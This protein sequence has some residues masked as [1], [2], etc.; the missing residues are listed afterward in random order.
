MDVE[1]VRR[2]LEDLPEVE[3]CGVRPPHPDGPDVLSAYVVPRRALRAGADGLAGRQVAEW[4]SLYD[5][6]YLRPDSE[7]A[8]FDV[9]GWVSSYTDLEVPATE[10]AEWLGRA[11]SRIGALAPRRV[12][13]IGCGTGLLLHR[14]IDR[15]ESYAASDFSEHALTRLAES[16]DGALPG[17][18]SLVRAAADESAGVPEGSVDTVLLNSVV[19]YFPDAAYLERVVERAVRALG[20]RGVLFVGDVRSAA[21]NP[22]FATGVELVRAGQDAEPERVRAAVEARCGTGVELVVD[23]SYF[24]GLRGR[25]DRVAHVAVMP[26]RGRYRNE[27]TDYRY[28]VLVHLDEPPSALVEPGKWTP[29]EEL[30]TGPHELADRLKRE[31]PAVLGL[32][33]VPN[34][35][36]RADHAAERALRAPDLTSGAGSVETEDR[37]AGADPEEFWRLAEELPYDAH[38]SWASS[39]P[40]GSYDVALVRRRDEGGPGGVPVFPGTGAGLWPTNR[41]W[42]GRSQRCDTADLRSRLRERL[43]EESVPGRFVL[44]EDL[45]ETPSGGFDGRAADAIQWA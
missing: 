26:K 44:L 45:P 24:T 35:R 32:T 16:F 28:D 20:P 27:M 5:Y 38:V 19:Q 7:K 31:R 8:R 14:L 37:G 11:L 23:P 43:P 21:V 13:E 36:V 40:D 9:R 4:R 41:P 39:A 42:Q 15:V 12:W 2:E 18:L 22:A 10:M 17:H 34:P 6:L 30:G 33:A 29:W 3:R 1:R 25:M